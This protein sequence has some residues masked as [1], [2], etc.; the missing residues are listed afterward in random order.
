MLVFHHFR[1]REHAE[2]F[3]VTA[4]TGFG[5]LATVHEEAI[6]LGLFPF[7][8]LEPLIVR[9][10]APADDR[11]LGKQVRKAAKEFGGVFAGT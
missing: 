8:R 6:E 5:L 2:R 7:V 3:A 4:R 1:T 9:V 10:N 11:A